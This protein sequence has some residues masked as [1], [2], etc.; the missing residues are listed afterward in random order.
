MLNK[1]MSLSPSYHRVPSNEKLF[2]FSVLDDSPNV[3]GHASKSIENL[4]PFSDDIDD[5]IISEKEHSNDIRY[6]PHIDDCLSRP[7]SSDEVNEETRNATADLHAATIL[8]PIAMSDGKTE[9]R[10]LSQSSLP[11][12]SISFA[13][14][15]VPGGFTWLAWFTPIL[16]SSHRKVL[17]ACS[18][19]TAIARIPA[20]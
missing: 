7:T 1:N 5:R 4:L 19:V 16:I 12:A 15:S 17:H 11:K 13:A 3:T 10:H 18:V 9:T 8:H 20:T 6:P 2:D 14:G